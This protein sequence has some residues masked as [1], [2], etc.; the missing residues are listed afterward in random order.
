MPE[1]FQQISFS[2]PLFLW[3]SAIPVVILLLSYAITHFSANRYC[4]RNLMAWVVVN[5]KN[6]GLNKILQ[7]KLVVIVSWVLFSVALSGPRI[8]LDERIASNL[9]AFDTAVVFVLDV[10][11]SMRAQDV[12]PDRITKARLFIH[13][14]ISSSKNIIFSL[15]VFSHNAH[16]AI[17][18][19]FDSNVILET[20]PSISPEMLPVAGSSYINGLKHAENIL[21]SSAATNKTIVLV[22]DGDF[23]DNV[24]KIKIDKNITV[25]VIGLGTHEG[26]PLPSKKGGWLTFNNK[27]VISRINELNLKNIAQQNGGLYYLANASLDKDKVNILRFTGKTGHSTLTGK[28][29]VIWKQLYSWFLVP[30]IF[31]FMLTVIRRHSVA[32]STNILLLLIVIAGF[33]FPNTVY[34]VENPLAIAKQAYMQKNYIKAE[35]F[36]KQAKGYTAFLGTGNALYRQNNYVQAIQPYTRAVLTALSDKQRAIAI[37][38][39]ANTYYKLGD[40]SESIHLYRDALKYNRHFEKARVNLVYAKAIDSKVKKALALRQG[41]TTASRPGN[42]PRSA[43]IETGVDVGTS[44]LKLADDDP[45]KNNIIYNITLDNK[46]INQLIERGI[47]HSI[48]SSTKIDKQSAYTQWQYDYTT[49]DMIELLVKQEKLDSFKLWKRLFEIEEGFPA[50]VESPAVKPGVKPW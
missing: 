11:A 28:T 10:S 8:S 34:A 14:V 5:T 31:L 26:Q 7:N 29:I 21:K 35:K 3:A 50:P 22:S 41:K 13:N 39:L 2:S 30:A 15:V 6:P 24:D 37:Y 16:T 42:G 46:T 9:K 38:N 18:L 32:A 48:V 36:Y 40:Y 47:K 19:T 12:Y 44:K 23:T 1:Y 33:H 43:Q 4:D 27:P 25:N 17:P 20:L 49:T 45:D